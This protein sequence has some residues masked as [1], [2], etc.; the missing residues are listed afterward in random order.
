M[1]SLKTHEANASKKPYKPNSNKKQE[2]PQEKK[3]N[4]FTSIIALKESKDHQVLETELIN[5][6]TELKPLTLLTLEENEIITESD[7][8][9]NCL[10]LYIVK[11][12]EMRMKFAIIPEKLGM[13]DGPLANS[14]VFKN[15]ELGQEHKYGIV[16]PG[17]NHNSQ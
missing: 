12:S 2:Q 10:M 9:D 7:F 3:V 13:K 1:E 15:V 16:S 6:M 14:I 8:F 11:V 17:V 4:N 5:I